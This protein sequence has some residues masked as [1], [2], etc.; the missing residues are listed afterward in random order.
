[1]TA[2]LA[3]KELLANKEIKILPA[4]EWVYVIDGVFLNLPI[5]KKANYQY[6][7]EHWLPVVFLLV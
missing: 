1:M 3:I 7:K 2:I 5:V 4:S 6:K